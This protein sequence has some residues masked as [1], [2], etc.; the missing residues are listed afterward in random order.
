MPKSI[1]ETLV[2][3]GFNELVHKILSILKVDYCILLHLDKS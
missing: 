2:R 3:L 1:I